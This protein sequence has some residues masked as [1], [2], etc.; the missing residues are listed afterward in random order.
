M[1]S[2]VAFD[3]DLDDGGEPTYGVGEL[4]DAINGALRRQFSDGVWV[5]GEIQGFNE[6]GPHAYFRLVEDT[7]DGKAVLSVQFFANARARLRPLL[8]KHRLRLAD[9][10]KVRIFGHIDYFAP[11]GQ[12]GLKMSGLDP[13]FTLGDLA[14][15]RDDV[16]RRLVASGLYD[17]NRHRPLSLVPLRVGVVA[18]LDSAAW[19]DFS[20]EIERS[21]L[22]FSLRVVNVR[23]QG[24]RAV[25][26]ITAA[27]R[28]L[29]RHDDLD[30]VVVIRGGG[31][32]S[33]LATF[34][35]EPI[36]A[37]IATSP[38][39]VLTGLGHEIDRS[40]ADEVAH[41][42]LKTPTACAAALV[43]RVAAYRSRTDEVWAAI[44]A[45]A[46]E[47]LRTAEVYVTTAGQRLGHRVRAAVERADE[48]LATRHQRLAAASQRCAERSQA[49][50]DNATADLRRVSHRLDAAARSL[51]AVAERVRLLDPV[52]TLARGWSITRGPDGRVVRT[53]ADLRVG[54]VVSTVVADGTIASRVEDITS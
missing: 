4:A 21:R 35:Q 23:V 36:A 3:L 22:G 50:I 20:H 9:G 5:R 17:A 30:A 52:T 46:T 14:L 10:L 2:Q 32:R 11:S 49:R 8:A 54:D 42:A 37:A 27:I 33:E 13:R 28:T 44:A 25:T 19:A 47:D 34:D 1:S 31:S 45:A 6:R 12:L 16:V 7:D 41:L 26:E 18:S 43:E 15:Q 38:I 53:T 48:R 24:E 51:D 39:P 40:V 29:G